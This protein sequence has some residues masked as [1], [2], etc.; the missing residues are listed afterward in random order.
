MTILVTGANSFI[1]NCLISKLLEYNYTIIAVYRKNLDKFDNS[2][3]S[4]IKLIQLDLSY[5]NDFSK[6]IGFDIDI[7]FHLAAISDYQGVDNNLILNSNTLATSNLIN[8]AKS[9]NLKKFIFASSMSIYG[10][11]NGEIL[12]TTPIL[13]PNYYGI[14]KYISEI[15]L[16]QSNLNFTVISIRLPGI[17]GNGSSKSLIPSIIRKLKQGSPIEI[18]NSNSLFNNVIHIST[19]II[20][21]IKLLNNNIITGYHAFPIGSSSP[22]K[23]I[24]TIH[25]LK[26][27]LSSNS[28]IL[29]L[30]DSRKSFYINSNYAISKLSYLPISTLETLDLKINFNVF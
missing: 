15:E 1:G 10:Q 21:F 9:L 4:K 13:K 27:Q 12:E 20:F 29:V 6:L 16:E 8:F 25:Y 22:I 17:L 24:D 2:F 11:V 7:I 23:F 19:L 18:Y 30:E 14:S 5:K 26:N 28:K 3:K